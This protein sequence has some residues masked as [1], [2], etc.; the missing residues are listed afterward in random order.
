MKQKRLPCP[1]PPDSTQTRG[2]LVMAH[3]GGFYRIR[4]FPG[5]LQRNV[6][7]KLP[8]VGSV[9]GDDTLCNQVIVE[10]ALAPCEIHG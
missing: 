9:I 4:Q 10:L 7:E 2:I 6:E 5:T 8:V 3:G 1:A